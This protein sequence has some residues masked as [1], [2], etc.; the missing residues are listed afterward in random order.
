MPKEQP[1]RSNTKSAR[2]KPTS[3]ASATKTTRKVATPARTTT[4]T[5][6]SAAS[7]AAATPSKP[8]T[9]KA[10]VKKPAKGATSPVAATA[11]AAP[12][13]GRGRPPKNAAATAAADAEAPA[14]PKRSARAASSRATA[15]ATM[16]SS[17][18]PTARTP[19]AASKPRA[20]PKVI[21]GDFATPARAEQSG[22]LFV[23]GN[24]DGG[25]L[26]LG[27]NRK[28]AYKPYPVAALKEEP[29]VDVVA[30]GM[31]TLALTKNGTVYSWGVNDEGALG[32]A[33]PEDGDCDVAA[34]PGSAE[35]NFV[36]LAAGDSISLGLT[37]DG[38]IYAWGTFRSEQAAGG[39]GFSAQTKNATS[40]QLLDQGVFAQ[41]RW[42]DIAAGDNHA[43]AL[44]STGRVYGWG[45]TEMGQC[46]FRTHH[47]KLGLTPRLLKFGGRRNHK[48]TSIACGSFHSMAIDED[49][50][51]W[52]FGLNNWG[53]CGRH[54]SVN[55]LYEPAFITLPPDTSVVAAAGGEHHTLA[56]LDDG[57]VLAF[58]RS[59]GCE[60]GLGELVNLDP[61]TGEPTAQKMFATETTPD[62]Q[63]IQSE[64][65]S[66]IML[67]TPQPA[68]PTK[69]TKIAAGTHHC[70]AITDDGTVYRWGTN[71]S[72]QLGTGS[73]AF[74][75]DDEAED[76]QSTPLA[77][78]FSKSGA[79][80]IAAACGAQHS[81]L[82]LSKPAKKPAA[83]A[84]APTANGD[85]EMPPASQ[86]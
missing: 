21:E 36:K 69:V 75:A 5:T 84:P 71:G 41:H 4:R 58:G 47:P 43:L 74:E 12:K 33:V 18:T 9:A 28:D 86:S 30:G 56:L 63:E 52:M 35:L 49:G 46:G 17:A 77:F 10:T 13:R 73:A 20:P 22:M 2:V 64:I 11:T 14:T 40:P 61:V 34:I 65:P 37:G 39:L 68:Y 59:S 3:P 82:L 24:G 67:P 50:D 79:K 51:L 38:K 16:A 44:T 6:R 62:G 19:R 66:H 42:I 26:G 76:D 7:A 27:P 85:V 32:R 55:P 53:Q 78:D 23:M 83:A 25:Q 72:A 70:M 29:V 31:H 1:R 60:L 48:I 45:N 54:T 15:A 57:R 80:G 81:V 8:T